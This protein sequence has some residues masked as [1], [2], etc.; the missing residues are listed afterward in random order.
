M[1][2]VDLEI[3]LGLQFLQKSFPYRLDTLA[4]FRVDLILL[5]LDQFKEVDNSSNVRSEQLQARLIIIEL[6][7]VVPVLADLHAYYLA[8]E[9]W[10]VVIFLK[11]LVTN[12]F[13]AH[14]IRLVIFEAILIKLLHDAAI[15]VLE[16]VLFLACRDSLTLLA[17]ILDTRHEAI[18]ERAQVLHARDNLFVELFYQVFCIV[19]LR[20]QVLVLEDPFLEL[21]RRAHV[22]NDRFYVFCLL[23]ALIGLEDY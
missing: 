7:S 11:I 22:L 13:L 8:I 16:K 23:K 4:C 6:L 20:L 14:R 19:A 9:L 12:D 5:E 10:D 2:V 15:H 17:S 18:N 3:L 1:L 21:N